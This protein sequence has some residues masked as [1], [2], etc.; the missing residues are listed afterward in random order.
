MEYDAHYAVHDPRMPGFFA[1]AGNVVTCQEV[2]DAESFDRS[3]LV[4]DFLIPWEARR[5]LAAAFTV[6]EGQTGLWAIMRGQKGGSFTER[7]RDRL[8]LL[9]PH[10]RRAVDLQSR[11]GFAATQIRSLEAALDVLAMPAF[12]LDRAGR[13]LYGN[14]AAEAALGTDEPVHLRDGILTAWLPGQAAAIADAVALACAPTPSATRLAAEEVALGTPPGAAG[15]LLFHRLALGG[16]LH[17]KAGQ[18]R[19]LALWMRAEDHAAPPAALLR[20]RLGLTQG[21]A[22]LCLALMAGE[23]MSDI[24]VRNQVSP[25]TLRSQLKNIFSKTG[26]HRQTDLI[27]L[28]QTQS[29]APLRM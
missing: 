20:A 18:A 5:C 29:A 12:V 6:R 16:G 3:A 10:I 28:L 14:E 11:L 2:V 26:A 1:Q 8:D 13:L 22:V 25:E 7:E 24:A 21:E 15:R 19:V 17:R 4:N 9:L 23:R 27:R